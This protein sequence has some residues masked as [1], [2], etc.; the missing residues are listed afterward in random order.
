MTSARLLPAFRAAGAC[1]GSHRGANPPYGNK[2][3]R[4]DST[5]SAVTVAVGESNA[6]NFAG[7]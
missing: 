6:V 7:T 4:F 3:C 2:G 5:A 1:T